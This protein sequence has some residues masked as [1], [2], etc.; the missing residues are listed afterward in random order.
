LILP[1]GDDI[2]SSMT[3]RIYNTL[4]RQKE[5]FIPINEGKVG[6][7]VCGVTVY[8]YSHV[9]HA[10]SAIVFDVIYRYLQHLGYGVN[11]VR[12]FTDIDDKII[13]RANQELIPC[14]ELTEKFI[15]AFY[16]D[17]GSLN[18]DRPTIEPKATEH[19]DE[20]I[21][22]IS[23]LIEQDKAYEVDGDVF[24]SIQSFKEY[25][26]LSGK[27]ID[28][29]QA[30]ARVEVNDQKRNSMDFVLWKKSKMHEPSWDS[31]W[32]GGRPGW[33]IECSA[34]SQKYLGNLFD[35]HGGGKDLVFPHHENE[36]AQSC[37]HTGVQ[38]VKYWV[39][40]GFVNINEEKMSKSLGNFF[41]IR[42]ILKIYHPEVL[43]LFLLTNHY[44]SPIDFSDQNLI[45]A[46]KILDRY[47]EFFAAAQKKRG[48]EEKN[49]VPVDIDKP[50]NSD[51]I[52]KFEEAMNDDFNTALALAHLG[53]ELKNLNK[54][55]T[56]LKDDPNSL[57]QFDKDTNDLRYAGRL[58]GIFYRSAEDYQSQ[59][60]QIKSNELDLDVNKVEELIA[61]RN[62]ARS[63][64]EWE[65]S[66]WFRD[67]LDKMGVVVEDSAEGTTWKIK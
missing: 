34:M 62:D 54:A 32:G 24:Y 10:R 27:N 56:D 5:D 19:I 57:E 35:I 26:K 53:D 63:K 48:I 52:N 37:G 66:D 25:G 46:T 43:R 49:S 4:T 65:R 13:N 45:E 23:S 17:M 64:K 67:E 20:M 9:G 15:Q 11:Y 41:T 33:H 40:N 39:H 7:Y 12:N 47:Y 42:D 50:S 3:L 28:D 58:L 22:M 38:P 55:L 16:D 1:R 2:L 18:I 6:M 21:A 31:P 14:E 29:L 61:K 36:I 44:R 30:G 59:N 51:F 8:D 60:F